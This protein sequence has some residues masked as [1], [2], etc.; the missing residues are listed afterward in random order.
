M[1]SLG[2]SSKK[3]ES[4]KNKAPQA[5]IKP[6]IETPVF[7]P[8]LILNYSFTLL[9]GVVCSTSVISLT[10]A[11]EFTFLIWSIIYLTFRKR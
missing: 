10:H 5:K 2:N 9:A 7:S 4:I 8:A 1:P 3:F 11:L 6:N